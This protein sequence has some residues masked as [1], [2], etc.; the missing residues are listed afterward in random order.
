MQ[1]QANKRTNV[2]IPFGV[3]GELSAFRFNQLFRTFSV[4]NGSG[5]CT[6]TLRDSGNVMDIPVGITVN[7]DAAT[8]GNN[9]VNRFQT[10]SFT[11]DATDCV[12]VGTI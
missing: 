1:V 8:E 10:G 7:F 6:L 5:T 2:I 12:I 11:V 9:T 4:Y 3:T